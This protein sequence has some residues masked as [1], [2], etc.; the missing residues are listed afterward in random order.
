[1]SCFIC[2]WVEMKRKLDFKYVMQASNELGYPN[3]FQTSVC[4]ELLASLTNTFE[5]YQDLMQ[6]ILRGCIL[7]AYS[8]TDQL[9]T[10]DGKVL[11]SNAKN[12]FE[13]GTYFEDVKRLKVEC[14]QQ[15]KALYGSFLA[16][17]KYMLMLDL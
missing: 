4:F 12:F 9:L 16:V 6:N 15:E 5:R 17:K 10:K 1:M 11:A 8:A 3:Q 13:H 7:G 2:G 14:D